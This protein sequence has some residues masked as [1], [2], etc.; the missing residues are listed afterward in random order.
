[1]SVHFEAA[2][3]QWVVRWREDGRNRSRRFP[4]L[5]AAEAFDAAGRRSPAVAVP[6]AAASRGDG[7]YAY[8]TRA[9]VRFRFVFRQSDGTMSSRRGFTSRRAA[10]DA[11]RRLVESIERGEVKVARD[12]F[13]TFW[14]RLLQERR[15]YLTAGSFVDFETH[16]RKRLLPVFGDVPLA[17]M[18]EERVRIWLA[19]MAERVEGGELSA[20]T[21]NNARTCL[22]VALNEACRRGLI[23]RNPCAAVPALPVDRHELDYLRLDEIEP[24]VD[25]CM[26]H[27]RPLARFLIGTGARVS[28]ALAIQFRHL[29]L[30]QGVAHIY[31][32]RRRD[33][34][35]SQP[36]KGKRFRSVQIGPTLNDELSE[37]RSRRDATPE[38]W[39]FLCPTPRRGRYAKRTSAAPPNRRTVH[40][41]HETALVDAGLR[42]MPLHALRHSAAA[43]WLATGHP[44]IFVQRQL[45]HRSITTTEEHYGHLERSFVR[46][47]LARTESAIREANR[48]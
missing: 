12:S 32:Q 7:I 6:V 18:D 37:L 28:E 20:K 9:G 27:Y 17:R 15:P 29:S 10:A 14:A 13:G 23:P 39:V 48:R 8:G 25:A 45:G 22:A 16:G 38:D 46:E 42:D 1:M 34:S 36:T 2:R 3:T 30:D 47:A 40:D 24:Y 5:E 4:S 33:G 19:T 35:G 43:A 44:L 41:W 26:T 11:R 21:V 31:R